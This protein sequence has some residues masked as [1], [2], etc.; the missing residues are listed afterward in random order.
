MNQYIKEKLKPLGVH[1]KKALLIVRTPFQAWLAEKV[2]EKERIR[3]FD[4]IYFT[5]N[6]SDED[7]SYYSE[8]KVKARRSKYIFVVRQRYDI[9]NHLNFWLRSRLF[10]WRQEYSSIMLSSIESHV[11]NSI[12]NRFRYSRLVTFDDGTANYNTSGVYFSELESAR[13]LLYRKFFG[14]V[15]LSVVKKRISRHYTVQPRL[16]NIVSEPKLFCIDGWGYKNQSGQFR[17]PPKTY[18]LGAPF[19]EFLNSGQIKRLETLVRDEG[20]DVYVRHPRETDPLEL[21]VPFLEKNG[22]IAEEAILRDSQERP[23]RLIGSLSSVMFNLSGMATQ[24]TVFVSATQNS[25]SDLVGI[26]K[27]AGCEVVV[28]E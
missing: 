21:G 19:S 16:G 27:K 28:F 24:R 2:I 11:I 1:N 3:N 22:L 25:N 8:L 23:I 9:L 18:F 4:V 13:S 10:L 26:A 20:V 12:S 15:P 17:L 5:Q 6:D 14:G 7:R